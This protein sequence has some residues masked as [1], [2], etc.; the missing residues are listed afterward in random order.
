MFNDP[1]LVEVAKAHLVPPGEFGERNFSGPDDIGET[2]MIS[3]SQNRDSDAL[4]Q[5]NFA[6]VSED[7]LERFPDDVRIMHASHWAV[8]WVDQLIVRVL[9]TDYKPAMPADWQFTEAFEAIVEWSTNLENYPVADESDWSRREHEELVEYIGNER[10]DDE[11]EID[12]VTVQFETIDNLPNDHA[13]RIA[14]WLFNNRSVSNVESVDYKDIPIAARDL[15][16]TAPYLPDLIEEIN[17]G[18][19]TLDLVRETV[20]DID[21]GIATMDDLRNLLREDD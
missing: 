7:M 1:F 20:L 19:K 21:R 6:V 18:R 16:L 2:H 17:E 5:S 4:A 8:G 3:I 10:Y 9:K 14:E 13:E 12:G 15:G 11:A